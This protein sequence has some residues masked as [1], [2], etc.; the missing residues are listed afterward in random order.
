LDPYVFQLSQIYIL[1]KHCDGQLFNLL[2]PAEQ[3]SAR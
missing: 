1:K 3:S 2:T